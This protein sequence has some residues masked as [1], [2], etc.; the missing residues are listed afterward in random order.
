MIIGLIEKFQFKKIYPKNMIIFLNKIF[1]KFRKIRN[2]PIKVISFKLRLIFS[3]Q[4]DR[5]YLPLRSFYTRYFLLNNFNSN[6]F[7][8]IWVELG[9]SK[10]P[11]ITKIIIEDFHNVYNKNK[12]QV[13]IK[14]ANEASNNIVDLLGS[15]KFSFFDNIKWNVDFKTG[16]SWKN[17]FFLDIDYCNKGRNSDVKVPWELSR[18]QWMIPIGQAYL[19]TSDEKYSKVSKK[20]FNSWIK[21]NPCGYSVNW[22]CTMEVALRIITLIWFFFIFKDSKHWQDKSFKKGFLANLYMHVEFT[23]NHLEHSS[24]NGNHFTADIVGLLFGGLFFDRSKS[25]KKWIKKSINY[26]EDEINNQTSLDGVNFEGSVPYHRLVT[27]LYFWAAKYL[28][29]KGRKFSENYYKKLNKMS[30]FI[31][32]Y[33]KT[34]FDAPIIGDNDNA[35]ILPFG[36]QALNNHLYL[37]HAIKKFLY[38]HISSIDKL[39]LTELFWIFEDSKNNKKINVFRNN[40]SNF[41]YDGGYYILRSDIDY[42]FIDCS[43]VGFKGIGGHGHNDCLSFEAMLKNSPIISDSGCF[44][45]TASYELRN[46]FR[47]TEYHNTPQINQFEIN[48]FISKDNLWMLHNDAKPKHII[49]KD[50]EKIAIFKGRH[51]GY[52]RLKSPILV[53]RSFCLDKKFHVIFIKD[54]IVGKGKNKVSIPFHFDPEV[55]INKKRGNEIYFK[56]K[57]NLFKIVF[58]S[59]LQISLICKDINISKS[60]GK[61]E[62][63]FKVICKYDGYLPLE[64]NTMILPININKSNNLLFKKYESILVKVD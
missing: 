20:L 64:I 11:F 10:T 54:N 6:S 24:I 51:N 4:I 37:Y 45:Y 61:S 57:G 41:F 17:K 2:M 8:E 53:E 22:S 34:N 26:L 38:G 23:Y 16:F 46:A 48:R 39:S 43:S 47:S 59:N 32:A 5:L 55:T 36:L 60:Y 52:K 21:D 12:R 50:N 63:S 1:I 15:G 30:D 35:R 28:R 14:K 13:L 29:A 18:F 58:N 56:S 44:T 7:D 33:T 25:G 19:L 42:I 3:N 49:S 62:S 27:E 40:K 9:L 31:F